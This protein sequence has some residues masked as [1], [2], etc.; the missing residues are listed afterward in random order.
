MKVQANEQ[1][2]QSIYLHPNP[3]D[4]KGKIVFIDPIFETSPPAVMLFNTL[5]LENR[6]GL[7]VSGPKTSL[8]KFKNHVFN[9]DNQDSIGK[10]T[11]DQ[12][13]QYLEDLVEQ[14]SLT[15]EYIRDSKESQIESKAKKLGFRRVGDTYINKDRT[16]AFSFHKGKLIG[17]TTADFKL[18][19]MDSLKDITSKDVDETKRLNLRDPHLIPSGMSKVESAHWYIRANRISKPENTLITISK[20]AD[21]DR[22]IIKSYKQKLSNKGYDLWS[23]PQEIEYFGVTTHAN[24]EEGLYPR[25][26]AYY[27]LRD[28]QLRVA[29]DCPAD[30]KNMLD[31]IVAEFKRN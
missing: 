27:E 23:D 24:Y 8:M 18:F 31:E 2:F 1:A 17:I 15:V 3:D 6:P 16:K 19:D 9:A 12:I 7:V 11:D 26:V 4:W 28:N 5:R 21:K 14:F 13:L 22:S 20:L 25:K 10:S 30:L 29:D